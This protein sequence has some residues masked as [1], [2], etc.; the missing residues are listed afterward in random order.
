MSTNANMVIVWN[1]EVISIKRNKGRTHNSINYAKSS[2]T[3]FCSG[4]QPH[5]NQ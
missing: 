3:L 1:F 5:C 2:I 4:S